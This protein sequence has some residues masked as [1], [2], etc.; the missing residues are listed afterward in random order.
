MFSQ[1][2]LLWRYENHHEQHKQTTKTSCDCFPAQEQFT[3][4][5]VNGSN[6]HW[7]TSLFVIQPGWAQT[8]VSL[9]WALKL[10]ANTLETLLVQSSKLVNNSAWLVSIIRWG[11][12][13]H[14]CMVQCNVHFHNQLCTHP[15]IAC[16]VIIRK[17]P[18]YTR[19]LWTLFEVPALSQQLLGNIIAPPQAHTHCPKLPNICVS[20]TL[21]LQTWHNYAPV[22]SNMDTCWPEVLVDTRAEIWDNITPLPQV[23]RV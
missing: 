8:Q 21:R 11:L 18:V 2:D 23:A 14:V 10:K 13:T 4:T 17:G 3:S 16:T 1:T 15:I 5:S 12:Y 9:S 19:M 22:V 20:S 7:V 6:L